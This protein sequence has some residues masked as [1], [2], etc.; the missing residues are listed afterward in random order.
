M[1]NNVQP[2]IQT[3]AAR[4]TIST[5]TAIDDANTRIAAETNTHMNPTCITLPSR[6][7]PFLRIIAARAMIANIIEPIA[8]I[9]TP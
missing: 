1:M 6:S 3:R 5:G 8:P 7:T 9:V 2:T 4:N